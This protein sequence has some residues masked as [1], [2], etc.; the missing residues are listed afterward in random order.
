MDEWRIIRAGCDL[1]Y[2]GTPQI[3]SHVGDIATDIQDKKRH[4]SWRASANEVEL[5]SS[6]RQPLHRVVVNQELASTFLTGDNVFG[7]FSEEAVKLAKSIRSRLRV[8]ELRRIRLVY[9]AMLPMIDGEA[10]MDFYRDLT[11][12]ER[13]LSVRD[14]AP[15]DYGYTFDF[16]NG[17]DWLRITVGPSKL[18]LLPEFLDLNL[19]DC[20]FAGSE[21]GSFHLAF[22]EFRRKTP[23]T[24][25]DFETQVGTIIRDRKTDFMRRLDNL[26]NILRGGG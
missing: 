18:E 21:R 26:K 25:Q 15:V 11:S 8:N 22:Y 13:A 2:R 1:A 16:E 23:S 10:P 7:D 6:L 4:P 14:E 5:L 24:R 12:I 20:G 9:I 19:K 17:L 3:F